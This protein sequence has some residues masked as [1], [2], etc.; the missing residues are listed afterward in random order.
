MSAGQEKPLAERIEVP[1]VSKEA[2]KKISHLE[3]EFIRAEVEQLRQ[4]V[5]LLQPL[6]E[7][8]NKLITTPEIQNDF[9]IRVFSNA[10][11]DIDEYVLPSDAAILGQ[12]LKN[13]TVERFEVD[14]KGQG[15]PRSLRFTFEFQ[16]GD[17]NPFFENEKLVKEFY[18]RTQVTKNAAG[19]RRTWEGLVSE[20]VRINWKEGKDLT[21]GLLDA[22]CDLAEAEKKG[23]D[24]KKLPE[25][26]KLVNKIGEVQTEAA[27]AAAE[28]DEDD[29]DP[30]S[31]A[32]VSF[33]AFFGYRGRSV[34]AEE[35][36][37]GVK[38][39]EERWAKIQKG[40]AVDDDDDDDD[41]DED[42]DEDD[43]EFAEVFPDGEDLAISIAE[44]L[45]PNALKY[46]VQ[47]YEIAEDLEELDDEDWDDEEDDDDEEERPH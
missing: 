41:D 21:K 30:E 16:T 24:R 4:S 36:K 17:E 27:A 31:P 33:F 22:A 26:E 18:W 5:P 34:S 10:P 9:W 45:W 32:G 44:D 38:E 15:E 7:K 14:E 43:L 39:E 20:P 37:Q 8:R 1:G 13:L 3:Q 28:D 40:E 42:D 6:Y 12:A 2:A 23:G 46:F 11:A 19:K 25:F 29:E 47:S 35:S